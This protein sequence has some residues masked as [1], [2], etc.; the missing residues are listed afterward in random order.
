MGLAS[1]TRLLTYLARAAGL[2]PS[3]KCTFD[4]GGVG[5]RKELGQGVLL[6]VQNLPRLRL[7]R[8]LLSP[9]NHRHSLILTWQDSREVMHTAGAQ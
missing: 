5:G 3:G 2:A 1:L 7:S 9:L 8:L 6:P 4:S